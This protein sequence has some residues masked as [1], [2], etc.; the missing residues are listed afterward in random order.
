MKRIGLIGE[1]PNDTLAIRNLLLQK[2]PKGFQFKQLIKNKKGYQLNNDRV[3]NALKIE[4]Q[5]FKP[6]YVI[7][8]RDAD[9]IATEESKIRIVVD[10]FNKLNLIVNRRGILLVNIYELEALI[11]ADIKS[12]NKFYG[13]Q[14]KYTGNVMYQAKPKEFLFVKTASNKKSYSE[15]DCPELFRYL[16]FDTVVD[17]C[18]YFR[19]FHQKFKLL[20]QI[21]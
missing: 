12:F 7:F 13:T 8:I 21:K 2:Y 20:V 10:W 1:D 11:L 3:A 4:F 9:A 14:I 16:N 18:T 19:E 15:S 6:D 17:S 5:D